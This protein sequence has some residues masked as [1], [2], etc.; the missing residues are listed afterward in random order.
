[1][2]H[3]IQSYHRLCCTVKY[4]QKCQLTYISLSEIINTVQLYSPF[5]LSDALA[6][7]DAFQ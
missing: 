7:Q 4:W 5:D 1:M 6:F 3:I 2:Y